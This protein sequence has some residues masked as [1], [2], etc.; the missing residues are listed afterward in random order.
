MDYKNMSEDDKRRY[1]DMSPFMQA[2]VRIG[3]DHP[4]KQKL[5]LLDKIEALEVRIS[6]LEAVVKEMLN[7]TVGNNLL[8]P[9]PENT[10][11]NA[12]NPQKLEETLPTLPISRGDND[13]SKR[14][15]RPRKS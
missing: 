8:A 2:K 6:S 7:P 10:R 3:V 11:E 12:E 14:R 13:K 5:F 1:A 15:G 4:E 9:T